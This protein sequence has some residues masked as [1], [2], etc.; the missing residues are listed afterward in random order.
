MLRVGI[1]RLLTTRVRY[2]PVPQV[3]TTLNCL[4]TGAVRCKTIS[5]Y[6][7]R[8]ENDATRWAS[9]ITTTLVFASDTEA[10]ASEVSTNI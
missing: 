1:V 6:S 9:K 3:V 5:I 2:R 7:P 8:W 4:K 10:L